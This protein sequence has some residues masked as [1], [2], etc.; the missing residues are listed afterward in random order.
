MDSAQADQTNAFLAVLE[1]GSFTAAGRKLGRDGSVISRR[2]AALETRL[3]IRLLE[4]STRRVSATEAGTRFRARIGEAHAILRAAED[5]ARSMAQTPTGLLRI[6]LPAGFGRR[7]IAPRLPEFLARYPTLE[8]ECS[9]TDRYV[10]LIAERYD[11]GLRIGRLDDNRLL[12]KP[13]LTMQRLLCASP[14]WVRRHGRIAHPRDLAHKP[15]IGFT[16][17]STWPIWHL[18]RRGEHHALR[19]NAQLATDDVDTVIHAAINGA[20]V[21]LGADWVVGRELREGKLVRVLP[22]WTISEHEKLSVVR[23]S[24]RNEPAKT[25]AFV[26]WLSGL[27]QQPPWEDI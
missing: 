3:G 27:F 10:D 15:C 5:E 20:G 7:W 8:V 23:A 25:R 2:V 14:G 4:R 24:R 13:L 17:L 1:T 16:P 12:A 26:D 18:H 9:L 19:V 22:G 6:S 21:M 11:V